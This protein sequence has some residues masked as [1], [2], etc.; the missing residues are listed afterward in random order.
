MKSR[1]KGNKSINNNCPK[2]NRVSHFLNEVTVEE[3]S[4]I[5]LYWG[6]PCIMESNI[7]SNNGEKTS[8]TAEKLHTVTWKKKGKQ[9]DK[10]W[11]LMAY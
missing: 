11:S 9:Q 8:V 5:I 7:S 2:S 10:R 6:F 4:Q 3:T 1:R